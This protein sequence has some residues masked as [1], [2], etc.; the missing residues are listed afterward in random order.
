MSEFWFFIGSLVLTASIAGVWCICAELF[1]RWLNNDWCRHDW[2][3]W[4][5]VM[6]EQGTIIYQQTRLCKKC[7]KAEKR[8]L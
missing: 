4:D 3:M 8:I 5:A 7:N 6:V 1:K 2:G